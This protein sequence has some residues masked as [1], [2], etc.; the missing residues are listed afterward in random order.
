MR[1]IGSVHVKFMT[2]HAGDRGPNG[3]LLVVADHNA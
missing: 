1:C 2:D 3:G